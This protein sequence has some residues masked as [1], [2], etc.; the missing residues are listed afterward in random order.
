MHCKSVLHLA[1]NPPVATGSSKTS[2]GVGSPVRI[3]CV[4]MHLYMCTVHHTICMYV[5]MYVCMFLCM[6]VCMCVCVCVC[7]FVCLYVR[8]YVRMFVYTYVCTHV[9]MLGDVQPK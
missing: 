7:V 1:A 4:A 9:R 2:Y 5:C 3:N 8:M 6:Y